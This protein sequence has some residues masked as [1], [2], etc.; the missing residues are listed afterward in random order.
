[1]MIEK[2]AVVKRE[3][4]SEFLDLNHATESMSLMVP[5]FAP[6]PGRELWRTS[7]PGH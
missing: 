6:G 1:M 5:K 7:E 3:V 2:F 4:S